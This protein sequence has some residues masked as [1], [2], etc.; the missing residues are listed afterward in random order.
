MRKFGTRVLSGGILCLD[1]A[2][3]LSLDV[4][5]TNG[6]SGSVELSIT[7]QVRNNDVVDYPN[8]ELVIVGLYEG[9]INLLDGTKFAY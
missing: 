5:Q 7:A 8:V 1:P 3:D 9:V 2:K 6:S 4:D